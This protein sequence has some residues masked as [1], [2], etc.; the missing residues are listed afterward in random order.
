MNAYNSIFFLFLN[1]FVLIFFIHG[2]F[3]K[4]YLG[5]HENSRNVF[6]IFF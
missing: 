3:K 6:E 1:F 2:I 4:I 5:M